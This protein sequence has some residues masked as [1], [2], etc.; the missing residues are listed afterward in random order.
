MAAG[1]P[2]DSL[3]KRVV[4]GWKSNELPAIVFSDLTS[5]DSRV[6]Y[7]RTRMERMRAAAPF[8]YV[9]TDPPGH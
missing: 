6:H 7:L 1:V 5:D 2:L 8:L 4:F 3:L 9:D